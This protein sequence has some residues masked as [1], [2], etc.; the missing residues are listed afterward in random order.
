MFDGGA[1]DNPRGHGGSGALLYDEKDLKNPI[2]KGFAYLPRESSHDGGGIT[3]NVA[4][5]AALIAALSY[6]HQRRIRDLTVFSDSQLMVRQLKGEYRVKARHL[7]PFFRKAL[8]LKGGLSRFE[9]RHV[10]R[11]QNRQADRLANQA[12]DRC[13]RDGRALSAVLFDVDLFKRTNDLHGHAAGDAVLVQGAKCV[14]DALGDEGDLV[15]WGGEEFLLV[16]WPAHQH[17]SDTLAER[18]REAIGSHLFRI[19]DGKVLR[20]T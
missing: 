2:W 18:L 15:R 3:N 10:R 12:I 8:E 16:L 11:E 6:A 14:L 7:Q 13:R 17:A 4:E 5:Y 1:R 9:I 20:R 19:A